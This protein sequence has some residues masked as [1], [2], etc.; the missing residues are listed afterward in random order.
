MLSEIVAM[1]D[2]LAPGASR[3]TH[4]SRELVEMD[5]LCVAPFPGNEGDALDGS[6]FEST[7]VRLTDILHGEDNAG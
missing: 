5:M 2:N 4:F 1:R 6:L 7:H 3:G